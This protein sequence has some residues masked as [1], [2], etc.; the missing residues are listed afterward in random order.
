MRPLQSAPQLALRPT[1]QQKASCLLALASSLTLMLHTQ[2][3]ATSLMPPLP[4]KPWSQQP[5]FLALAPMLGAAEST[6]HQ[7]PCSRARLRCSYHH[8]SSPAQHPILSPSASRRARRR[9]SSR[10][11]TSPTPLQTSICRHPASPWLLTLR[12]YHCHTS[13]PPTLSMLT[14]ATLRT[15]FTAVQSHTWLI[16][17]GR[18]WSLAQAST[19][20]PPNS[21]QQGVAWRTPCTWRVSQILPETGKIWLWWANCLLLPTL[22]T[23]VIYYWRGTRRA[24][25]CLPWS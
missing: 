23:I 15:P 5:L 9:C 25:T 16:C 10:H 6:L 21:S 18:L 7:P 4:V 3:Q 19:P 20:L 22:K 1:L 24:W 13:L 11:P 12:A 8:P 2:G 17:L 14:P